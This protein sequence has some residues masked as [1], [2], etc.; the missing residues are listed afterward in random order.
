MLHA[1]LLAGG[2][3]CAVLAVICIAAAY[4]L[5]ARG[6]DEDLRLTAAAFAAG[7]V[8]LF[9]AVFLLAL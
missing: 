4:T 8:F 2:I 7:V 1:L 6:K 5:G 3:T 9:A